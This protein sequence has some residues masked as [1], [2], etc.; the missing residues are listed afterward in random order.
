MPYGTPIRYSFTTRSNL[1]SPIHLLGWREKERT[2]RKPT[3]MWGEHERQESELRVKSRSC[4][5]VRIPAVAKVG[6][7]QVSVMAQWLALPSLIKKVL[8]LN[9]MALWAFSLLML[10]A[11]AI[12][13]WVSTGCIGFLLLTWLRRWV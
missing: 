13:V 3:Q 4:E 11:L 12:S 2:W 1:L 8:G 7:W 9:L 6:L 5:E 10:R